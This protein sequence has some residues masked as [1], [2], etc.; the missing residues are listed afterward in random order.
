[1]LLAG[2]IG[3]TKTVLALF[4]TSEQSLEL[5]GDDTF[6]SHAHAPFMEILD[7]FLTRHSPEQLQS[8]CLGVAGPV[9]DGRCQTTNLPWVLDERELA[10]ALGGARVKL[11]ND[12]EA[13]AFG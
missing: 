6:P 9:V 13:T 5:V 7:A 4:Q 2:D 8:A 12:L 1:M 11:L 10:Q 3:G